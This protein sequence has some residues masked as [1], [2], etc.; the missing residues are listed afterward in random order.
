MISPSNR[1]ILI[2][3][4]SQIFIDINRIRSKRGFHYHMLPN[5]MFV[6]T[7]DDEMQWQK[8]SDIFDDLPVDTQAAL[9]FHLDLFP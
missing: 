8:L 7:I 2:G 5:M 1:D 3:A 4:C 9:L 6:N